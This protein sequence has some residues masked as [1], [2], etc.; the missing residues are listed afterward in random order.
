MNTSHS[1]SPRLARREFLKTTAVVS[2]AASF[3]TLPLS[4]ANASALA[5][6]PASA[7][8][9]VGDSPY[10]VCA[11]L[12]G[13][14]EHDQ[15]PKNISLM[16]DAGIAWVRAD[17][18]WSGI[19][20]S[21]GKWTFDAFD[22]VVEETNKLGVQVL[23]ILDYGVEWATPA[24]KHMD[25][26][27]EYVRRTVERYKDRIRYWEVW[28]EENLQGFWGDKPDA[29]NYAKLLTETYKTIKKI[30][31]D[32]Q[33]VYGG[34]AGTPAD[35][36][37]K[38]LDAGA[39][40]FFDVTNIHP[41][42]GGL[43]TSDRIEQFAKEIDAFKKALEKR[44]LPQKPIWITEMGWATPPV[45][46]ETN[47][48]VIAAALKK[49]Y[50]SK[51]PKVAFFYDERYD[52]AQSRSQSDFVN[53]LPKEYASDP[54]LT[55]FLDADALA[56]ISLDVAEVLVMPPSEG[57]P[58]DY[59]DAVAEF[60]KSGGALVL[61]GGVPIY[62]ETRIDPETG[63]FAQGKGNPKMDEQHNALRISW[64]AWWTRENV[65]EGVP[66]RVAP[67]SLD[68]M[69]GYFPVHSS[70]RFFDGAKLKE[71]DKLIPL[72]IGK[73]ETFEAPSAC[74]YKFNS[75]YKGAVVI[76]SINDD[77]TGTNVSTVANQGVYLPQAILLALSNGIERYFWYEFH[78]PERD[79][80][81]PEHHFGIVGQKLDPKPGYFA[82]KALTKARPALS[83]GSAFTHN[84]AFCSISWTRPDG[85]KG[86]ALWAPR[87]RQKAAIRITGQVAE[88]FDYLGNKVSIS[89]DQEE[90]D[91][92]PGILY[93]VGPDALEIR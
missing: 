39:G 36:F 41:Y 6:S 61:L 25:E 4:R 59:F 71:G 58:T 74:V 55:T 90:I 7:E 82:Y 70:L 28:N 12:G 31:P 38:S 77:A 53:F 13:G 35:Y 27:L 16:K 47:R 81:D 34:L 84:G 80:A 79:Q 89:A 46:G 10:G 26:W 64:F 60:V 83:K 9:T 33:V 14:E 93:L 22:R 42:R 67:E 19:E 48:R 11:H 51:T 69:P 21:K 54:Q 73:D 15:M 43:T 63:R 29:A 62:Y 24:Y 2:L 56:K 17:F 20:R 52:P 40:E 65:P 72:L 30:D 88:A 23:P 85:K 50:P 86:W 87:S 68:A 37:E 5:D 8:A 66:T 45:F 76:N 57:F 75:D 49:L 91:L 18:S 3:E 92:S 78:A 1:S 32:L 44:N